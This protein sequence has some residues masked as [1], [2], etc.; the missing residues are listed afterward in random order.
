M[1]VNLQKLLRKTRGP[2]TKYHACVVKKA[3]SRYACKLIIMMKPRLFLGIINNKIWQVE[4]TGQMVLTCLPTSYLFY[5]EGLIVL[6]TIKDF[7]HS[8]HKKKLVHLQFLWLNKRVQKTQ[9]VAF[10]II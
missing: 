7:R 3:A 6:V 1:F 10:Y 9:K 2:L 5:L 8:D 4:P